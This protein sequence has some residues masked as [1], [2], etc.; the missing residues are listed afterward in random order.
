MK[1]QRHHDEGNPVRAAE[2]QGL[3]EAALAVEADYVRSDN[4]RRSCQP[5]CTLCRRYGLPVP[6]GVALTMLD[7][8]AM[9]H[10]R[11]KGWPCSRWHTHGLPCPH[12]FR[13]GPCR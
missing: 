13:H 7:D 10:L 4:G 9:F 6:H 5:G 11:S 3:P 12:G 1:T 2:L 8:M